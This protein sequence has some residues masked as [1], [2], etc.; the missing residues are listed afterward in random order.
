MEVFMFRSS[1]IWRLLLAVVLVVVLLVAGYGVYR[2]GYAQG[3]QAARL[4]IGNGGRAGI[5]PLPF[6]GGLPNYRFG[7]GIRFPF[8][9][10]FFI[11]FF[12][13][14]FFLL[15][16]FAIRA[17]F[18][19]WGA[20]HTASS[21][22]PSG[23]GTPGPNPADAGPYDPYHLRDNQGPGGSQ[24]GAGSGAGTTSIQP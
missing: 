16:F 12:W 8:F 20:Q 17:L 19:P 6:Y 14:G 10:S 2:L 24:P 22:G 23:I 13:I 18:R 3:Y 9:F 15:I 7:P 4:G 21:A 5:L 11:P 1:V